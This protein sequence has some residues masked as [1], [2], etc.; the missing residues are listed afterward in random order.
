MG[1]N[2]NAEA[3]F[4]PGLQVY[5]GFHDLMFRVENPLYPKSKRIIVM[6]PQYGIEANLTPDGKLTDRTL[7]FDFGIDFKNTAGFGFSY[8]RVLQVL[9]G[10]FSPISDANTTFLEGEEYEWD[11]FIIGYS[12]DSRK[13]FR[14]DAGFLFGSFY[15][16]DRYN[17]NGSFSYRYQPYGSI[18]INM[19]YND[20]R[21]PGDYGS[22]KYLLVS[23]R[24]DLTFTD[25]LF[26]T[27]F[28]QYNDRVDNVNLNT[29][30]QW[31]FA[32]ASD[33]FIVYTENYLPGSF[34]S[35]NRALV[36]KLT[37][38]FNI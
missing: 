11:E 7:S 37:Y 10:D 21:L 28:I 24:I 19:D 3:G 18:T 9:T 29:R 23:P 5:P 4:V 8:N 36:L 35:K 33:L 15:N 6:T 34:I 30:F 31:R 12:S 27:T 16:G 25:A 26:L 14:W 13:L 20:L 32:P 38:W 22:A 1:K 2:Y 17:L